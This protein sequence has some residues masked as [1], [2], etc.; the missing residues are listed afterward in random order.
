M[1]VRRNVSSN[2]DSWAESQLG[3]SGTH[4]DQFGVEFDRFV[5]I[6]NR[7]SKCLDF[8]VGLYNEE[9][10]P[11]CQPVLLVTRPPTER[12]EGEPCSTYL[13]SIRV[14]RGL[15]VFQLNSSCV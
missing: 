2:T 8:N 14:K 11:G 5:C 9:T 1:P 6:C 7:V 4:L 13:S 10:D 15:V 12:V 3:T